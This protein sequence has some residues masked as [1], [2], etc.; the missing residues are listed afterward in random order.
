MKLSACKLGTL[1]QTN[2]DSNDIMI[3]MVMGLS[4]MGDK[5][6]PLVKFSFKKEAIAFP[7]ST[8]ELYEG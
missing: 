3:G 1:V 5:P 7:C 8:L 2:T 6:E 4:E